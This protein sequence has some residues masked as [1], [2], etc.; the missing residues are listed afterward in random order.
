VAEVLFGKLTLNPAYRVVADAIEQN[1][2]SG[3]MKVG[4]RLPSEIQLAKQF[5]VHRST[6]REGLRLLEESGLVARVGRMTLE[7]TLPHF[8]QLAT[9]ASRA[10]S[11]HQVTFREL[12]EAS[13]LTEP[14]IAEGAVQNITTPELKELADNI[15][16]MEGS[17]KDTVQF[18]QCDI[19]FHDLIA[20]ASRNK[21]LALMREPISL[22]FLPAGKIILPRLKT[23]Q[24]VLQAHK[25]IHEALVKRDAE[26]VKEWMTRH[27]ADFRRGYLRTGLDPQ[28]PLAS[29]FAQG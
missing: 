9:R 7:V 22:L 24:R 18:V 25:R 26:A 4:D 8:Q 28:K 27:M 12:W 6:V 20:L 13:M 29:P 15:R 10:L 3:R 1:I 19:E 11:M 21:V 2:L 5:G 14:A 17:I 23:H 16:R